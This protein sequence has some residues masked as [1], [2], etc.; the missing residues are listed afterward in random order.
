MDGRAYLVTVMKLFVVVVSILSTK[1]GINRGGYESIRLGMNEDQVMASLIA[2]PGDYRL[3]GKTDQN[4]KWRPISINM[5]PN[6]HGPVSLVWASDFG[7]IEVWF[8]DRGQ[9]NRKEIHSTPEGASSMFIIAASM[10][11]F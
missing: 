7:Q 3:A 9:A 1:H 10:F 4:V 5:I 11:A 8:D 6:G 2:L